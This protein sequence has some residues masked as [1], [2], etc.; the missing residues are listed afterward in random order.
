MKFHLRH[1]EDAPQT[2]N[3]DI[4]QKLAFL[5]V[6]AE[7]SKSLIHTRV[8]EGRSNMLCEHFATNAS[9]AL[10]DVHAHHADIGPNVIEL[11][12]MF[13]FVKS[14]SDDVLG[15]IKRE[16]NF[17]FYVG[18]GFYIMVFA[19][20][21]VYLTNAFEV[22]FPIYQETVDI[23]TNMI[24]KALPFYNMVVWGILVADL[25]KKEEKLDDIGKTV[26]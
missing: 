18:W 15:E 14:T 7:K 9:T 5:G 26:T 11:R 17:L 3:G 21:G 1:N 12:E 2:P 24:W 23:L 20:V 4:K 22:I 13:D 10:V 19:L 6:I 8:T 25:N 16:K